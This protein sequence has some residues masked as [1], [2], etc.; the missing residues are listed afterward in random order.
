MLT[1]ASFISIYMHII[2]QDCV[3]E[4][5]LGFYLN[6][7]YVYC[8][9]FAYCPHFQLITWCLLKLVSATKWSQALLELFSISN[10]MFVL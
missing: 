4:I 1:V 2:L 7:L 6:N 5:V 3:M 10:K 8:P 9:F